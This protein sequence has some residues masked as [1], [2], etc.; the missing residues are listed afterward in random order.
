MMRRVKP[1]RIGAT[2][3]TLALLVLAPSGSDAQDPTQQE[4]GVYLAAADFLR[5]L[6]S[7]SVVD[8]YRCDTRWLRLYGVPVRCR[9]SSFRTPLRLVAEDQGVPLV[10]RVPECGPER[11]G[12]SLQLSPVQYD[13]A[14]AAWFIVALAC[15]GAE[16][17]AQQLFLVEVRRIDARWVLERSRLLESRDPPLS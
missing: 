1:G 16:G 17:L 10:D 13:A 9:A 3:T 12:R 11:D 6:G 7:A 8:E 4:S 14:D 15:G 2:T 5:E